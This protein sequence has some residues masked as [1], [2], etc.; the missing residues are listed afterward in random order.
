M[1]TAHSAIAPLVATL[2]TCVVY[3]KYLRRS[4]EGG[5]L[6]SLWESGRG[7]R[8]RVRG[9]ECN[10]MQSNATELKV[11]PRLATPDEA[12]RG[13]RGLTPAQ[14]VGVNGVPNG[15]T[16][17]SFP[18]SPLGVNGAKQSQMSPIFEISPPKRSSRRSRAGGQIPSPLRGE[19]EDEGEAPSPA[20]TRGM[21]GNERKLKVSPLLATRDEGKRGRSVPDC[22]ARALSDTPPSY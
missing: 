20:S 5:N 17:A 2:F 18:A 14:C 4:R 12:K 21:S 8:M 13:Q 16:P 1:T 19:G 10:R 6:A 15:A 9:K 3:A 11:S 22:G 7:V